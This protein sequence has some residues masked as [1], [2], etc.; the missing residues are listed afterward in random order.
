M[1]DRR[2][3]TYKLYPSSAQE[4]LLW[5]KKILLKDLWNAALEERIGAYRCTGK[6]IRLGEQEKALKIVRTDVPGW[7]GLVHTHEAQTVLKRLDLAFQAFFARVKRG[8]APGFPRFRSAERFA[9]WGYKEHGNGFRVDLRADGKHGHATLFGIGRMRIR[10]KARSAGRIC[11]ADV[12]HTARG[13]F[14]SV[15]I[16]TS[17]A[18]RPKA[19]GGAMAYDW[20]IAD[21]AS[22]ACEDGSLRTVR[23][24]RH[25]NRELQSLK[26]RQRELSQQVR[27]RAIAGG[28]LRKARRALA[29]A[30]A[31][32]AARRKDFLHKLSAQLVAEH[33]LIATEELAVRN[34]SASA[35]GTIEE[36][37]RNVA[38][39]AGLN[40]AI[41]DGAPATFMNMV[42][43]KAAEAGGELLIANTRTLKPSQRCPC[44]GSI[45]KKRLD[46][47][48]HDCSCGAR[49][50]R[51]HA[52]ALVVLHWAL[53][54]SGRAR[55]PHPLT[56]SPG[57]DG[58]ASHSRQA[59]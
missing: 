53:D 19:S 58:R 8:Q 28:A 22:I 34:M 10:G 24:P 12:I 44:C 4:A 25:L 56:Q 7:K 41:L 20:G 31:A 57:R 46:V 29:K 48:I 30:F 15:V 27:R 18:M 43:Y 16:E 11:K 32:L 51:D 21:Y 38:Q 9:G 40:R 47:R 6:S 33:D 35:R 2:T 23:N 14:L 45:A 54:Q 49:L 55:P 5:N 26:A 37:G 50:G 1:F 17:Q 52:A 42:R 39:K 59:A 36:P 3:I 13:W